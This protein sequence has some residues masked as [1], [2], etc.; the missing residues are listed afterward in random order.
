MTIITTII[1]R[2]RTPSLVARPR[3]SCLSRHPP[4]RPGGAGGARRRVSVR[5]SP[6]VQVTLNDAGGSRGAAAP[7][8][9]PVPA[10]ED[11]SSRRARPGPRGLLRQCSCRRVGTLMH[12]S[13]SR[14]RQPKV[15]NKT[16]YGAILQTR[17]DSPKGAI[18]RNT[19][20]KRRRAPTALRAQ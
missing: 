9:R 6:V 19:T 3:P 16:Q 20:Q 18:R 4:E 15:C 11:T 8:V 17:T 5:V 13:I 14:Y 10:A 12:R 1:I 2:Q 7:P